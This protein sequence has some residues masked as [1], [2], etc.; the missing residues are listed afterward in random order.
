MLRNLLLAVLLLFG[1]AS[2]SYSQISCPGG[3]TVE[4]EGSTEGTPLD[5]TGIATQ[6][7]CNNASGA[8]TGDINITVT[9]G[10][11]AYSY[12]WTMD[13]SN[14]S[15]DEDLENL[16]TGTYAVT[17]TDAQDCTVEGEWIITEPTPVEIAGTPVDLDCNSASGDANGSI[18]ITPSGGTVAGDYTYQWASST[19]GIGLDPTAQNQTGLTAGTYQVTVSDD[20]D[21]TAEAEFILT[22]PD[23]IAAIA[24]AVGPQCHADSGDPDGSIT[25]IVQGGD[26]NFIYNWETTDGSGLVTTDQNQTE[27]SAGTYN[28]T[29]TDGL[30][31]ELEAFYTITEPTPVAIDATPVNLDCNSAS[32]DANGSIGIVASGGQGSTEGDYTY[33]WET[34]DG[35]GL[36]TGS[37]SQTGLSAGT[38]S[39]TVSDA[40]SC[41]DTGEWTLTEPEAVVADGTP[42]SLDCNSASGDPTGSITMNPTGGDGNYSYTWETTD[43][44]GLTAGAGTQT[45]LSA[46]TYNV[47]VADGL[48]C[49]DTNTF[50]LTEPDAVVADGTPVEPGCN[51]ASGDATG[52]ITMNPTGGD[53]NYSYT[54]DT[55]DGSA[56]TPGAA[57]QT[58]LGGGTY[59]VTVT[60]GL[61][62]EAITSF[63]LSEPD[64]VSCDL[65]SPQL[66]A[67]TTVECYGD[68][69]V[70]TVTGD[71]GTGEYTYILTGTDYEG[72]AVNIGP[73][74]SNE[75][76]VP[77]GNYTV[78][79]ID[80]NGCSS[81]CTIEITHPDAIIAGTCS[82]DDDCQVGLGEIEVEAQGGYGDLTVT[83]T[84][85][86]GGTLDQGSQII[87]AGG[88]SVIF[89]GADG[90]STYIFTIEDENGCIIG[91]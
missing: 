19:G 72:N 23:A 6:P 25:L 90:G 88:G 9:G 63:T 89:T 58:S 57:T 32:G 71:G 74:A 37:A 8:L 56:L 50:T 17:V 36:V 62:C 68:D 87:P 27:L 51:A 45:G 78:E 65:D 24:T 47:T 21:C 20:N 39:L 1:T 5:L 64:A 3:L 42:V 53:G 44:S 76:T 77:A 91:G 28:V 26:G 10:S 49:E 7:E 61:G 75:F 31:C 2:L 59:N 86:D 33:T 85:P 67:D 11:P 83:W 73:Q 81:T 15:T 12:Q 22:E 48:G 34:T 52:S 69:A 84:S 38:Y 13:G 30:G 43:G 4:I 79:T 41:T 70:I 80:A 66:G 35:S 14:F 46:G 82:V 54:W 29:I 60:D 40:N 16:G 55:A 18:T